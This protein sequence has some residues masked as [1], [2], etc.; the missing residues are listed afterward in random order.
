MSR[1]A[2][3]DLTFAAHEAHR[4]QRETPLLTRVARRVGN[5]F[6]GLGWGSSSNG[7]N[8]RGAAAAAAADESEE[9][10]KEEGEDE[11]EEE[12]QRRLMAEDGP[13]A[14]ATA[15]SVVELVGVESLVDFLATALW[16]CHAAEAAMHGAAAAS[17]LGNPIKRSILSTL[18]FPQGGA[19]IRRLWLHLLTHHGSVRRGGRG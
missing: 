5:L 7:G 3:L 6:G 19:A 13:G 17:S 11:E 14:A 18:A 10:E 8:G 12:E 9:D 2:A 1:A 16:K 15:A 4:A